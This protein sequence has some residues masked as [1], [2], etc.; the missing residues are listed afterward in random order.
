MI[1]KER[2]REKFTNLVLCE[3]IT[4]LALH[5]K[6]DIMLPKVKS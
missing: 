3:K 6:H 1:L 5:I 2:E 4:N